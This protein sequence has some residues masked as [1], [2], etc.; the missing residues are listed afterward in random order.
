MSSNVVGELMDSL[1]T[2]YYKARQAQE[3]EIEDEFR[4]NQYK[5]I[6]EGTSEMIQRLGVMEYTHNER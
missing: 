6:R 1:R 3:N 2:I 5:V 4:Y